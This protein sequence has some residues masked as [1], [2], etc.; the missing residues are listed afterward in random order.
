MFKL[1]WKDVAVGLLLFFIVADILLGYFLPNHK[2]VLSSLAQV[3]NTENGVIIIGACII[4][5]ITGYAI[6]KR[7]KGVIDGYVDINEGI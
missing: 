2:M 1:D 6:A 3:M 7:S 5:F 4:A